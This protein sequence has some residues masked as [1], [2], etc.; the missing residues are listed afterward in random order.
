MPSRRGISRAATAIAI[1]VIV[2][3]AGLAIYLA[4]PGGRQPS[5]SLTTSQ[6]G[7]HGGSVDLSK[8]QVHQIQGSS[9]YYVVPLNLTINYNYTVP[10][11]AVLNYSWASLPD[12]STTNV[13]LGITLGPVDFCEGSTGQGSIYGV[14]THIVTMVAKIAAPVSTFTGTLTYSYALM[15]FP[16]VTTIINNGQPMLNPARVGPPYSLCLPTAQAVK[17]TFTYP[18]QAPTLNGYTFQDWA[19]IGLGSY[20]GASANVTLTL[21]GNVTETAQYR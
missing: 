14:V 6:S 4:L 18:L 10:E 7:T 9:S 15:K 2:A 11:Y 3:V 16:I 19:G 12:S 21:Q 1:V 5:S 13:Q 17:P 8:L 20:S